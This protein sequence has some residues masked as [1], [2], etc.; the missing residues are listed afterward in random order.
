M[1]IASR[2]EWLAK[3]LQRK[4]NKLAGRVWS[5]E[6]LKELG[7]TLQNFVRTQAGKRATLLQRLKRCEVVAKL[8]DLTPVD[9]WASL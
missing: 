8:V 5:E 4:L 7:P 9:Y 1:T 3:R 2:A 6:D